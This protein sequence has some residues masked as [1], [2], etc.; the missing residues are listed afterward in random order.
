MNALCHLW[1]GHIISRVYVISPESICSGCAVELVT[2]CGSLLYIWIHCVI[3]E[4]IVSFMKRTCHIPSL[5]T[6]SICRGSAIELVTEHSSPPYAL[7]YERVMSHIKKSCHIRVRHV[8]EYG[9][10]PYI[11]MRVCMYV[12]MCVCV[13][14]CMCVCVNV[15]TCLFKCGRIEVIT[16][17]G[18]PPYV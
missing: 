9:S 13:N 7:S 14:V 6:Q 15:R 3:Y 5:S 10:L 11:Y 8:T 12:C 18:S 2:E 1:I 16:E 4:Y 17:C